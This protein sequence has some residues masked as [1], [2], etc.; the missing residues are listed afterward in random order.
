MNAPPMVPPPYEFV[1]CDEIVRVWCFVTG[2]CRPP[3]WTKVPVASLEQS[4]QVI[5]QTLLDVAA[6]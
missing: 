2:L 6:H 3:Q 4:V 1:L 5:Y